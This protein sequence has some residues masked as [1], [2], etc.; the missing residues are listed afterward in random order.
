MAKPGVPT[1]TMEITIKGPMDANGN[2]RKFSELAH[3][4]GGLEI[5]VSAEEYRKLAKEFDVG[6]NAADAEPEEKKTEGE[7]MPDAVWGAMCKD[8]DAKE[9]VRIHSQILNGGMEQLVGNERDDVN[10]VKYMVREASHFVKKYAPETFISWKEVMD[11][12]DMSESPSYRDRHGDRQSNDEL[13]DEWNEND[14]KYYEV[15][16]ALETEL[17]KN[18]KSDGEESAL[19][20]LESVPTKKQVLH[21]IFRRMGGR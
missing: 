7:E 2:S 20:G 5:N 12:Y 10:A 9:F 11:D 8:P 4:F 15:Q 1:G 3:K 13:R 17:A 21:S 18:Y 6:L 14:S 19:T 16:P